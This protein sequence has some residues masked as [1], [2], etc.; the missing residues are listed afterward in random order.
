M[1]H[2]KN[3]HHSQNKEHIHHTVFLAPSAYVIVEATLLLQRGSLVIYSV[4]N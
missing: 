1:L 2:L 3:D 4:L